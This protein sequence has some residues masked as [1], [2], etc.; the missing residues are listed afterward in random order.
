MTA[1]DWAVVTGKMIIKIEETYNGR[2]YDTVKFPLLISGK[3]LLAGYTIDVT[4]IK[5]TENR[6]SEELE[7][8]TNILNAMPSSLLI[9]RNAGKDKFYL[10]SYNAQAQIATGVTAGMLGRLLGEIWPEPQMK[11]NIDRFN[12][13]METGQTVEYEDVHCIDGAIDKAFRVRAFL[14]PGGKLGIV[15]EDILSIKTAERVMQSQLAE[16]ELLLKEVHHRIKNN[17]A[18]IESL[19]KIQHSSTEHAEVKRAIEETAGR[20]AS[21][22]ILYEKLTISDDYRQIDQKGYLEELIQT[23]RKTFIDS[24]NIEVIPRI[25]SFLLDAKKTSALGII[26]NELLTNAMKYAFGGGQ[27]GVI[28]IDL[29]T[30]ENEVELEIKDD[31][32]GLPSGIDTGNGSG[33]GMLLIRLLTEQLKGR[34]SMENDRGFKVSIRFP[35]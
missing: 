32:K 30:K 8:N 24:A 23:V 29:T 18:S 22:R 16:K 20:I 26:V 10:E 17:F 15:L 25:E 34:L 21:S 7:R 19:L 33:F 28:T 27:K 11:E 6:L 12:T 13:V 1:D 4:A 31:G 3:N 2:Y 35:L 14:I 5:E 9:C